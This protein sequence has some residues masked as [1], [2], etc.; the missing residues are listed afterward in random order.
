MVLRFYDSVPAAGGF[1]EATSSP[2]ANAHLPCSQ[3]Q[4]C[5]PSRR[6]GTAPGL[7][8]CPVVPVPQELEGLLLHS[9]AGRASQELCVDG[10]GR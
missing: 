1:S 6:A 7:A 3:E 5:L 9:G 4:G 2:R 8:V 10:A